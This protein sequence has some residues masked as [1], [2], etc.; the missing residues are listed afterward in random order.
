MYVG[1]SGAAW[2]SGPGESFASGCTR[3]SRPCMHHDGALD[4]HGMNCSV[5]A[6]RCEAFNLSSQ[7]HLPANA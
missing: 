3:Q 4:C 6:P 1:R 5:L 2:T 7:E